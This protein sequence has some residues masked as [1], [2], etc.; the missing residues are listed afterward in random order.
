MSTTK[1]N[2][3]IQPYLNFDGRCEEA[4]KFYQEALGAEV[5]MKM[6]FKDSPDQS[7]I[8]PS[9]K[10][11][12]MHSTLRI[13]ESI[14]MATDGHSTGK[15]NFQGVSMSLTVSEVADAGKCFNA[16][17]AGGQVQMPLAKTFFSPSFGM[18]ADKY[19]LTWMVMVP[20]PHSN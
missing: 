17:A 20:G 1:T 7:N 14:V 6:H 8:P 19:G 15:P 4:I 9:S 3:I 16:L 13:G 12:V 2:R 5:L 10:D 18:V 11:K